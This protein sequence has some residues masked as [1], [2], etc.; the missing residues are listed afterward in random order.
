M[1]KTNNCKFSS[2]NNII[3]V[4]QFNYKKYPKIY[5]LYPT[6]KWKTIFKRDEVLE[7][8][9]SLASCPKTSG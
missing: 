8:F 9:N 7:Y 1:Q 5:A 3:Y 2:Y 4:K 6:Y